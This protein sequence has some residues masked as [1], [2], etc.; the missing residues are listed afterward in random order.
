[1]SFRATVGIEITDQ[2]LRMGIAKRKKGVI[3]L[4]SS[5][6]TDLPQEI[7]QNGVIKDAKRLTVKMQ[8]LRKSL[9]IH[10]R[11]KVALCIPAR[12][13]YGTSVRLASLG[14]DARKNEFKKFI[15]KN[16][17]ELSEDLLMTSRTIGQ[18]KQVLCV[19]KDVVTSYIAACRQ[20]GFVVR[21][22]VTLPMIV[23]GGSVQDG[24]VVV[25][26]GAASSVTVMQGG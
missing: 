23:A 13:L 14:R 18:E 3:N 2:F 16:I 12:L 15:A 1:M 5:G 21:S 4:L 6:V 19:R 20:A 25:S 9:K 7:V 22:I 24:G 8:E 26:V 17:P 11:R 10:G